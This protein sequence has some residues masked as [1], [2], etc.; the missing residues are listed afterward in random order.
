MEETLLLIKPDGVQR[1]LV[2]EIISR[3]EK[4]GW[5]LAGMKLMRMS[6]E[7]AQQHYAEHQGK[8]F[9]EELI[10]YITE[11]P[12]VAMVWR[13]E[14]IVSALRLMMGKNNPLLAEPGTIRGDLANN[15]TRNIVHGSDSL[16]SAQREVALFFK[17]EELCG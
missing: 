13:G 17:P 2:G 7:L 11:G 8:P 1:K 12:L 4:R 5:D 10:S 16:E 15:F 14:G 6:R 9:F 3:L